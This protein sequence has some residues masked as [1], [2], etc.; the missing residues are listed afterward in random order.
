MCNFTDIK[1]QSHKIKP[2]FQRLAVDCGSPMP[3]TNPT[4]VWCG[5]VTIQKPKIGRMSIATIVIVNNGDE[6]LLT[7][8]ISIKNCKK[9]MF[10]HK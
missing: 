7:A 3:L 9:W 10:Y 8:V 6:N 1:I 2:K 4:I 5:P